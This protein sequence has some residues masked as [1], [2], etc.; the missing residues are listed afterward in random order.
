MKKGCAWCN[1]WLY[2]LL[3]RNTVLKKLSDLY[4]MLTREKDPKAAVKHQEKWHMCVDKLF[5][6]SQKD[7]DKH[8]SA[9]DYLFIQDQ[10]GPR[11]ITSRG[12][13][14]LN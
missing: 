14:T 13:K 2:L 3:S 9:K 10:K 7:I 8:L 6:I 1:S 12:I 11:K 4:E 5:D